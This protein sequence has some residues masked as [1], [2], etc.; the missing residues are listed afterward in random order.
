MIEGSNVEEIDVSSGI[1]SH[2][3]A[4][5]CLVNPLYFSWDETVS[6]LDESNNQI[7]MCEAYDIAVDLQ[8]FFLSIQSVQKSIESLEHLQKA[9]TD[10]SG[11]SSPALFFD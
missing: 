4:K 10:R 3:L 11:T 9:T 2:L 8:N 5:D 6:Q 7:T 1:Q